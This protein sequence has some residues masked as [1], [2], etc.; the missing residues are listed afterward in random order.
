MHKLRILEWGQRFI[1]TEG[2]KAWE[3]RDHKRA[4]TLTAT[5]LIVKGRP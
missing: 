1:V 2:G 4:Y 5:H 3:K